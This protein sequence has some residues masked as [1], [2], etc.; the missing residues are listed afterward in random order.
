MPGPGHSVRLDDE[1]VE[2]MRCAAEGVD[3]G[4]D[5]LVASLGA[6]CPWCLSCPGIA[7]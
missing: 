4:L 6:S 3:P 2:V 1:A 5:T 7:P